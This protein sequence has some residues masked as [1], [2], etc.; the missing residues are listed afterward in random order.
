MDNAVETDSKA[1][2]V[3]GKS[4][5]KVVDGKGES[6]GKVVEDDDELLA[7]LFGKKKKKKKKTKKKLDFAMLQKGR[8]FHNAV[9]RSFGVECSRL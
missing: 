5:G 1:V 2:D 6:D 8:W 7:K 9:A 4:D 3:E